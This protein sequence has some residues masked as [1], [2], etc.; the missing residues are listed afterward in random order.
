MDLVF[1]RRTE[2]GAQTVIVRVDHGADSLV[3]LRYA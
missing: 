3:F 2:A 1:W